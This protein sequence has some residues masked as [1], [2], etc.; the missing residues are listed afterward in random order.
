[1]DDIIK[2]KFAILF[3]SIVLGIFISVQFKHNIP[4][5][6]LATLRS[7][8]ETRK[9]I[10]AI[11]DERNDLEEL[12]V[13]KERKIE[14]FENII[15]EDRD[16]IDILGDDLEKN[17]LISG[18][19][20]VQGSGI[21]VTL[22]D[23]M[24]EGALGEEYDLDVV[25]D[26]DILRIINDLRGAGAEA[27]S[28]NDERILSITEIK[29]GGPIIRA[30]GKSLGGAPFYIR[31]I[32]DQKLLSA[33]INAPNTYSYALK[34]IDQINVETTI[35]DDIEIPAY[36]GRFNFRYAKPLKEGD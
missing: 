11:I 14:E 10:D 7:I 30:N 28:I 35:E 2:T 27:I 20:D 3:S 26:V 24:A 8:Q 12:I 9:E 22:Y 29:C 4:A 17:K 5:I 6:P 18:L 33:A 13:E 16:I 15:H 23:N 25:H 21:V 19:K 34:T 36:R 32:G 31:A 1:M